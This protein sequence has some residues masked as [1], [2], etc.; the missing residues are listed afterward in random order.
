M[1]LQTKRTGGPFLPRR[2]P[3]FWTPMLQHTKNTGSPSLLRRRPKFWRHM[4]QHNNK[5]VTNIWQK[6]NR[7]LLYRSSNLPL[8]FMKKWSWSNNHQIYQGP[9]LKGSIISIGLLPLLLY[10]SRCSNIQWRVGIGR[11]YISHVGPYFKL[12]RWSYWVGGNWTLSTN[13]QGF[14]SITCQNCLCLIYA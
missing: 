14:W 12:H 6:R 13:I 4:Q 3:K 5:N 1:L 7:R 11:W 10:W 9:F 2:R 8:L